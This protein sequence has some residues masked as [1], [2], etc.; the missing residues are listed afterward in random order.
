MSSVLGLRSAQPSQ[1]LLATATL[2]CPALP[3]RV[4]S[5]QSLELSSEPFLPSIPTAE[6]FGTQKRKVP[7]CPPLPYGQSIIPPVGGTLRYTNPVVI[8]SNT[9]G[10]SALR[11]PANN[12]GPQNTET[13][14]DHPDGLT[15]S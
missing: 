3:S 1:P 2:T 14:L 10:G 8:Q 9:K 11:R 12:G 13:V 6:C 7:Y 4:E 15:L 5:H